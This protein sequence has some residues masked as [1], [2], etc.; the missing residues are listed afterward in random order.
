MTYPNPLRA[1]GRTLND[2]LT[3]LKARLGFVV[4]GA[5]SKLVDPLLISFLQEGQDY[6][7]AQM[8][9]PKSKKQATIKLST[10]SKLYD[11]HNDDEDEDI[12]PNEIEEIAVYDTDT[13]FVRL[14][15]GITEG[16]R[17]YDTTPTVP[18]RFD[19][20]NGQIELYPTPNDDYPMVVTYQQGLGRFSRPDDRCTV[21]S[22]LVL[23]YAIAS[24]K[25]HYQHN[26]AQTAGNIFQSQLRLEKLK[27]H[28]QQRYFCGPCEEAP[29]TQVRRTPNGGYVL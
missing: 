7:Y 14:R 27:Q 16:M 8:G 21:S 26:D 28:G 11:C 25:A 9:A 15:Q 18:E 6:V 3:E 12:D 20:L 2:L 29:R 1:R 19:Y 17:C 13:S 24:A 4:Q 10:G 5:G 23:L 22:R